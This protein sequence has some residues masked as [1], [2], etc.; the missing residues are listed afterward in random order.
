MSTMDLAKWQTIPLPIGLV[1]RIDDF[2]ES[3]E[4]RK[5]GVSSRPQLLA[6]IVRDFLDTW[7]SKK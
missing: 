6:M 2:L 7:D 3:K 1:E 5:M 4:A